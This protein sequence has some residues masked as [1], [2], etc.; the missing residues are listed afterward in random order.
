MEFVSMYSR[1]GIRNGAAVAAALIA[2]AGMLDAQQPATTRQ[3][4]SV[5][6]RLFAPSMVSLDSLRALLKEFDR[7]QYGT[8]R[9]IRLTGRIDSLYGIPGGSSAAVVVRGMLG[10]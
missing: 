7:E 5:V 1:G 4:D 8:Q 10:R 2:G 9:W 3:R 6:F